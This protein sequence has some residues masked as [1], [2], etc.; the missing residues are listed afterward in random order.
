MPKISQLTP[1][2]KA[3]LAQTP[4]ASWQQEYIETPGAINV[5]DL[6]DKW[7]IN[8][9]SIY[10]GVLR[11]QLESRRQA[12]WFGQG[13]EK[14]LEVKQKIQACYDSALASWDKLRERI[15]E[16][17]NAQTEW[18][19]NDLRAT[20]DALAK[21]TTNILLL[22]V[23]HNEKSQTY[24]SLYEEHVADKHPEDR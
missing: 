17:V 22:K 20:A 24:K 19:P 12:F 1:A 9:T 4:F 10:Q 14:Q 11:N 13:K 6:A 3:V 23:D 21:Y 15:E 7:H 2:Q 16:V 8:I 5:Q 18:K